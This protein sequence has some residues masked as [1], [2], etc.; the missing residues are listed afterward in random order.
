MLKFY[1]YKKCGTCRKAEKFLQQAGIV[2]EY[3]DITESSLTASELEAIA[4]RA[5]VP[6]KKLFNTSGIQY[7]ELKIKESLPTLSNREILTLLAGNGRLIKRPLIT[8]GHL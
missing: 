7:R 8:D 1:G 5:Q 3:I 4:E 2:F 6:L